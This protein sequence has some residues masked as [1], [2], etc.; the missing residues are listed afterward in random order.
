MDN[1]TLIGRLL[2]AERDEVA[3]LTP[4]NRIGSNDAL[5]FKQSILKMGRSSL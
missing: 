1:E 4:E 3:E 2:D 5:K